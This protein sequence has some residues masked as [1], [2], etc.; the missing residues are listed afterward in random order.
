MENKN[1]TLEPISLTIQQA[2]RILGVAEGTIRRWTKEG[3]LPDRRTPYGHRYFYEEEIK[4]LIERKSNKK[5]VIAK[6]NC[7]ERG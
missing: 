4:A 5:R 6:G 1:D 2:V 3:S 7:S